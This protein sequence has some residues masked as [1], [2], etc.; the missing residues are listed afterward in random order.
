MLR[1]GSEAAGLG[2]AV[3]WRG[4]PVGRRSAGTARRAGRGERAHNKP[5][6]TSRRGAKTRELGQLR[7]VPRL[8]S[9]SL[10]R[11]RLFRLGPR[12]APECLQF[13]ASA[14]SGI[15]SCRRAEVR[16]ACCGD[17]LE[18]ARALDFRLSLRSPLGRAQLIRRWH[19]RSQALI[20]HV[21]SV[22]TG[23]AS[24]A[25]GRRGNDAV[26]EFGF[27]LAALARRPAHSP[28]TTL[29]PCC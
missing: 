16:P 18:P 3:C 21:S 10:R 17:A 8:A 12:R 2:E 19:S 5:R 4:R 20:E 28:T 1:G 24:E 9:T 23:G 13:P 25:Q 7:P 22:V 14:S 27:R 29:G 26:I 15:W 11:S 6:R